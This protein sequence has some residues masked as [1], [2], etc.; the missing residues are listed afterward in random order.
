M[1][2]E[3]TTHKNKTITFTTVYRPPKQ[4]APDD[5][6]LCDEILSLIQNKNAIIIGDFNSPNVD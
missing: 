4:Q 3:V 2:V 5:I 6:A 1:Y